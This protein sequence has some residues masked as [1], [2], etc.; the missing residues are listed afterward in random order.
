MFRFLFVNTLV[1][2]FLCSGTLRSQVTISVKDSICD[3]LL[4]FAAANLGTFAATSYTW[5]SAPSASLLATPNG[6]A[7]SLLFAAPGIYTVSLACSDLSS[8]LTAFQ[9]VTVFPSPTLT[10]TSSSPSLCFTESCTITATGAST[11]TW[12]SVPGMYFLSDSVAFVSPVTNTVYQVIGLNAFGCMGATSFT[13][14]VFPVPVVSIIS[15]ANAVCAGYTSS[16]TAFGAASY[17][18]TGAN[19]PGA[20][21]QSS[22]VVGSGTYSLTGSNGGV[23]RDSTTFSIGIL[24]NINPTIT[25]SRNSMCYNPDSPEEAISLTASGA[26]TYIWA[27]YDPA[28]M[29]YSLGPSTTIAPTVTTCYTLTGSSA[30]CSG[31]VVKCITVSDCTGLNESDQAL[32]FKLFPNPVN[33]QLNIV[34]EESGQVEVQICDMMGEIKRSAFFDFDTVQTHT[35]SMSDLPAGIYFVWVKNKE[36]NQQK[37]KII[38]N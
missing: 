20:V 18:W 29:T 17:T 27:P 31:S 28:H 14:Y 6:S 26:G 38:K 22:L 34:S 11:Y 33:D 15:T 21:V 12:A 3:G 7:T 25:A 23:C 10:L 35:V 4:G 16:I 5:S 19:L 30:V 8:T 1:L 36:K 37:Q 2:F 9:T 32:L 24:P 13:Q